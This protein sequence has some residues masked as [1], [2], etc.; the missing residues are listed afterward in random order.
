MSFV[1]WQSIIIPIRRD[2]LSEFVSE[3]AEG[4]LPVWMPFQ[5]RSL[6]V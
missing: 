5:E 2:S 4:K 6:L 3:T 1:I